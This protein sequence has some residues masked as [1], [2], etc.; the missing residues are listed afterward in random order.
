MTTHVTC[1]FR[2][3]SGTSAEQYEHTSWRV[4]AEHAGQST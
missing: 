4:G 2:Q 3:F 1:A